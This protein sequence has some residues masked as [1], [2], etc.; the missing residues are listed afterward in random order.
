MTLKLL[1]LHVHDDSFDVEYV[2]KLL[3]GLNGDKSIIN[4]EVKKK[5]EDALKYF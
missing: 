4:E 5:N 2:G 3:K 1:L